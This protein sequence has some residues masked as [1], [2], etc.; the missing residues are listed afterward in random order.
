MNKLF[1]LFFSISIFLSLGGC[2]DEGEVTPQ[3]P[4]DSKDT[5]YFTIPEGAE[6]VAGLL[7]SVLQQSD[8]DVRMHQL[9]LIEP[10]VLRSSDQ[11][12]ITAYSHAIE[13]NIV[14][15]ENAI[16]SHMQSAI[17]KQNKPT[18]L[19]REG[20]SGGGFW[21]HNI[22][23]A[24]YGRWNRR[25]GVTIIG[26][27]SISNNLILND[28]SPYYQ[29]MTLSVRVKTGPKIKL[30][31]VHTLCKWDIWGPDAHCTEPSLPKGWFYSNL[32]YEQDSY[33]TE[34]GMR[35][36]EKM[37]VHVDFDFKPQGL[38]QTFS[39]NRWLTHKYRCNFNS[40][41]SPCDFI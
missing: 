5:I 32:Y 27:Y 16:Y 24:S 19:A 37:Y 28:P 4:V 15:A 38:N 2:T 13:W 30:T 34:R 9:A 26:T 35:G 21:F 17:D 41:Y 11:Q 1:P 40:I 22:P 10:D 12:I 39:P 14:E 33:F 18:S 8:A 7:E 36:G 6:P 29:R 31:N 20:S 3:H 25:T 23:N